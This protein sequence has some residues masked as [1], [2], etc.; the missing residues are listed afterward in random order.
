MNTNRMVIFPSA[1]VIFN[2]WYVEV[3]DGMLTYWH[4]LK[5]TNHTAHFETGLIECVTVNDLLQ[6]K[7]QTLRTE[8]QKKLIGKRKEYWI[9]IN[10]SEQT[11][12]IVSL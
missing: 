3:C 6:W 10:N 1:S 2:D 5:K 7:T 8:S 11:C 9:I 4:L 12:G